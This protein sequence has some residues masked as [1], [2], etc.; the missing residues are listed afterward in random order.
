MR[1]AVKTIAYSSLYSLVHG[2]LDCCQLVFTNGIVDL[3]IVND[4]LECEV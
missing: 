2:T 4:E 3:R 1:S